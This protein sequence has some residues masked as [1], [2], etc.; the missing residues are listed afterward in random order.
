MPTKKYALEQ[1]GPTRLEV[2]WKHI[3]KNL[4][5]RFDGNEI[6]SIAGQKELKAG[7]EFSVG[8]DSTLKVQLV[9][10]YMMPELHVLRNGQAVP[11]STSDP[12]QRLR[13]A[14]G[15]LFFVAGLSI[16]AGLA[17]EI[18][19]I[20]FLFQLGVDA[21]SVLFGIF[22]LLLGF[23]VRRR[24]MVALGIATVLLAL[25]GILSVAVMGQQGGNPVGMIIV[26]LALL[27]PLIQAF[28]AIRALRQGTQK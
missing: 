12:V 22:F 3:W 18:F 16:V 21:A 13:V 10:N 14:S 24:S 6:G 20:K 15:V 9:R 7:Q 19:Q 26:R 28:P 27:I 8:D 5:V 17:A 23:F 2:S 1:S 25:D 11:G 4:T